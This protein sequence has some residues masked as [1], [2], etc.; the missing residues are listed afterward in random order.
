MSVLAQLAQLDRFERA[1]LQLVDGGSPGTLLT[2]TA[3]AVAVGIGAA[4]ALGPGHGKAV[5]AA[6]CVGRRGRARHAIGLGA[7]VAG[8]HTGSVLVLGTAL[9][10]L[11]RSP[12]A[13]DSVAPVMT[14]SAG[15]LIVTVGGVLL[16]RTARIGRGHHHDHEVLADL[17]SGSAFSRRGLVAL[18]L[19]GGLL[20]S[21]S[22]FLVLATAVAT[23]QTAFGLML[24]AG[25]SVGLAATLAAVGLVALRGGRLIDRHA[26]RSSWIARLQR[27]VPL[28]SALGVLAGGMWVTATGV[29]QLT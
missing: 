19:S 3:L 10:L 24:V 13:G 26:G 23:D 28:V 25:F 16:L 2:V 21:P 22:A 9:W 8:M 7:V 18:G 17:E 4:H 6:F 15:L 12:G 27:A 29:W 20:P 1:F 11:R 14:L 5:V